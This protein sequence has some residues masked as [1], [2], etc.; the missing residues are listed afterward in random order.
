M[1]KDLICCFLTVMSIFFS[2]GLYAQKLPSSWQPGM[3]LSITTEGGMRPHTHTIVITDGDS[4]ERNTGEGDNNQVGFNF[5]AAELDGL[6]S[7]L[8][9]KHF[10]G[11]KTTRRKRPVADM[12]TTSMELLWGN[13]TI[14]I[15]TGA[16]METAAASKKDKMAIDNY[17]QQMIAAKKK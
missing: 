16:S 11:I 7:F 13:H 6:M 10:S 14:V 9:K 4:Y 1:K 17:I 2:A 3:V 15:S 8:Q 12:G 5:T